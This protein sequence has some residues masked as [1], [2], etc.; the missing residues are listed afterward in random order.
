MTD[1]RPTARP[2]SYCDDDTTLWKDDGENDS[3]EDCVIYYA[4]EARDHSVIIFTITIGVSADFDLMG[5][6]AE[7]TGGVFR[8]ADNPDQLPE[9]FEELY[10]LMFLRLIK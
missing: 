9:I 10:E 3:Y 8:P 4:N 5:E 6:V 2:N 7:R 1:G